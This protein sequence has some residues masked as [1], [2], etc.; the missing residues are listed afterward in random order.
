MVA[1]RVLRLTGGEANHERGAGTTGMAA[2]VAAG[3]AAAHITHRLLEVRVRV[4]RA[5]VLA[6]RIPHP[7]YNPNT[8]VDSIVHILYI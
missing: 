5:P 2:T 4:H 7:V 3:T 6:S 1:S 8:L